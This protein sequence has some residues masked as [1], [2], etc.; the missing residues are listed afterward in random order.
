MATHKDI[1]LTDD[2]FRSLMD[3]V[4]KE[5][6]NM[7]KSEAE[8]LAKARPGEETA[9]EGESDSSK[10]DPDGDA[11][12]DASASPDPASSAPDGSGSDSAPPAAD[13]SASAPPAD[14]SASAPPADGSAAPGDPAAPGP[15][16]HQTLVA[17]YS[18]LP[19][20]A[21][22]AHYLALKE[23][24]MAVMGGTEDDASAGAPPPDASASAGAP[25]A[26]G[27]PAASAPPTMAMG[28]KGMAGQKPGES[29]TSAPDGMK[30][31]PKA[32]G[33]NPL[34]KAEIEAL[35]K[36]VNEATSVASALL[37]I[38]KKVVEKPLRK[39]VQFAADTAP[40]APAVDPT[41][42]S[43]E[44]VR[45]KLGVLASDPS[46]KKSDRDLISKFDLKHVGVEAVAHLLK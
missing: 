6:D 35:T 36:K 30:D 45:T 39:S 34:H 8:R 17:E 22:K 2:Q 26:A 37:G 38:V 23:A 7:A 5:L 46:L 1:T 16:D 42:L 24:M 33:E 4:Q 43:R 12:T 15:L 19:L 25:P 41:K 28:E 13:A 21:M 10:S 20:E 29:A 14:G 18:Q 44:E 3:D 9:G 31:D 27:P 40:A 11:S 32:N